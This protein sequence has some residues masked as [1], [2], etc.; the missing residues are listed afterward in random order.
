MNKMLTNLTPLLLLGLL[1]CSAGALAVDV[2]FRGT[3]VEPP[4]CII[5]GGKP[6]EV[7]F[8][9]VLTTRVDGKNYRKQMNYT[10]TCDGA[11][12]NAMTMQM[13][14][15]GA[16]FDATVLKTNQADLGIQLQNL[17]T[18][19]SLATPLK[20]TFPSA[21]PLFAVPVQKAG[22]ALAG[23]EFTSTA[24]LLVEYQ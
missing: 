13:N 6:I 22:A 8:G 19:W 9:E 3:L 1:G 11:P 23:G 12:T 14:G 16:S 24:S 20:F 10:L 18:K 2:N 5:N 4:P 21:P 7:D 17:A 15:T